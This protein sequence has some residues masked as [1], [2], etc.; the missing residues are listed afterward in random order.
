MASE[1]SEEGSVYFELTCAE[2]Q[3]TIGRRYLTTVEDMDS[4]RNAYALDIDKV[5]TYELGKCMGDKQAGEGGAMPPPTFYASAAMHED[6]SMLKSNM[7]A[8]AAHVQKLE[9]LV[10]RSN[11]GG[12]VNGGAS[13]ISPRMSGGQQGSS[14]KRS[15]AQG[16]NP[17]IYH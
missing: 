7:A 5:I 14:R 10:A 4:I 16:L 2:C 9:Q 11:S 8:L 6:V 1:K 3:A 12:G 17:E 15:Q 13:S